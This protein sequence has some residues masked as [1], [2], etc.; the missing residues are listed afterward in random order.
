MRKKP[1]SG[2]CVLLSALWLLFVGCGL[3]A[4]LPSRSGSAGPINTAV[5]VSGAGTRNDADAGVGSGN[6][7]RITDIR[8]ENG[9]GRAA[10]DPSGG[11][12]RGGAFNVGAGTIGGATS[13]AGGA[14]GAG[15]RSEQ[16]PKHPN[17]DAGA[18][19]G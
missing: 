4:D 6:G 3:D 7:A 5:T 13:H 12:D 18:A 8:E 19:N 1:G 10:A 9:A 17:D 2:R 15:G 11:T 14:A 16:S